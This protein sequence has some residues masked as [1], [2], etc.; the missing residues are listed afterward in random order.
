[1]CWYDCG[2]V[3]LGFGA[4]AIGRL[5]QG[6]VQN[7]V[8]TREYSERIAAGRLATGKGYA[9][10]SDDQFRAGLIRISRDCHR[11]YRMAWPQ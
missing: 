6:Y 11:W 2:D 4:S 1:M 3:L 10:T 7:I 5:S 8:P 9:L